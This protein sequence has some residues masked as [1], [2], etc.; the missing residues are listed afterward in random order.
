MLPATFSAIGGLLVVAVTVAR[1]PA[2]QTRDI[3]CAVGV[4]T[5]AGMEMVAAVTFSLLMS[6]FIEGVHAAHVAAGTIA[7]LGVVACATDIAS[8]RIP[9]EPCHLAVMVGLGCYVAAGGPARWGWVDLT[10]ALAG[11][12]VVPFLAAFFTRGGLGFGD[13]R[14][15]A[16][17]AA[18]TTWWAGYTLPLY[19]VIFGCLIQMVARIVLKRNNK[20]KVA[21]APAL[22]TAITMAFI[23]SATVGFPA[24]GPIFRV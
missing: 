8:K 19:G 14:L 2:W 15:L 7:A 22:V 21:F 4:K 11:L 3:R 10:V 9:K 17:Y 24:G 16:A 23:L 5:L 20:H 1:F 18:T 6:S 13:I 12:V